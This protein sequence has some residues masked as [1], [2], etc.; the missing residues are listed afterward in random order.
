MLGW[1]GL[2]PVRDTHF[3]REDPEDLPGI[4]FSGKAAAA[5]LLWRAAFVQL[6]VQ[7]LRQLLVHLPR[8]LV[9]GGLLGWP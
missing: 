4:Y 3:A 8:V 2:L 6:L 5:A 1:A 9:M 7:L